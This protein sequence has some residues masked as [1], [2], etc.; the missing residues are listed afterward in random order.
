VLVQLVN[1]DG[2]SVQELFEALKVYDVKY[3]ILDKKGN[4]L[5]IEMK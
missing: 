2:A 3:V 5:K 4:I 1:N